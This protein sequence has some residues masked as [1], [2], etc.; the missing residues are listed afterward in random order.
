MK[1]SVNEN[2]T[3]D[4]LRELEQKMKE[5]WSQYISYLDRNGLDE[6]AEALKNKYFRIYQSYQKNKQ[7]RNA[8][9]KN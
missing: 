2:F 8:I 7:W 9:T 5:I 4:S 1:T 6:T 3:V